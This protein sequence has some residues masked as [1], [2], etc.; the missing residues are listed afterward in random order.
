MRSRKGTPHETGRVEMAHFVAN[1]G[2]TSKRATRKQ[3]KAK[4]SEP[5]DCFSMISTVFLE[6]AFQAWASAAS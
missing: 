3:P 6:R 2:H 4:W 1:S 5:S